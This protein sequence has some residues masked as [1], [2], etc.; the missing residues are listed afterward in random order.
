M[1]KFS[2]L[3]HT[4][5]IQKSD[6]LFDLLNQIIDQFYPWHSWAKLSLINR[7]QIFFDKGSPSEERTCSEALE[8]MLKAIKM[9]WTTY[10]RAFHQV[11][12]YPAASSVRKVRE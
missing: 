5:S 7:Q 2:P 8:L 6:A 1:F 9:L 12:R 10:E 3:P 11:Q 4:T